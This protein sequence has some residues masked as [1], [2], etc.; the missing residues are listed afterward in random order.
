MIAD[1]AFFEDVKDFSV[2][3]RDE[4]DHFPLACMIKTSIANHHELQDEIVSDLQPKKF[5]FDS[6]TAEEFAER[7][8]D[9]VSEQKCNNILTKLSRTTFKSSLPS[10]ICKINDLFSYWGEG[11][12]DMFVGSREISAIYRQPEW[13][14]ESCR[15]LKKQ[16]FKL[17]KFCETR[18]AYFYDNFKRARNAFERLVRN[19]SQ[20]LKEMQ[21]AEIEKAYED[22]KH[23]WA[24]IKKYTPRNLST[25]TISTK[26]L[27]DCYKELLNPSI[28]PAGGES[29]NFSEFVASYLV[30][31]DN[32][33]VHCD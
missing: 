20:Q 10:V 11:M 27:Y 32:T 25:N 14:D 7:V 29:L 3:K 22:Q 1:S 5:K 28:E 33:C 18:H 15:E 31:H 26:Q 2:M 21:K 24:L 4:S 9:H 12:K 19:K 17:L 13:F 23:F 16:K 8:S 30:C 6:S